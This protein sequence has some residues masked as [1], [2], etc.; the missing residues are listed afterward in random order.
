MMELRTGE[1]ALILAQSHS[2]TIT[3]TEMAQ[4]YGLSS[5]QTR[6]IKAMVMD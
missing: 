6:R 3:G 2:W 5:R 1:P 4:K